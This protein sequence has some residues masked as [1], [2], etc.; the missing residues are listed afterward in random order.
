MLDSHFS[1]LMPPVLSSHG[2][3]GGPDYRGKIGQKNSLSWM[4]LSM[5]FSNF[6][7]QDKLI[8]LFL[9]LRELQ[10]YNPAEQ[11]TTN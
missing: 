2:L 4:N 3:R 7:I 10:K 11:E 5:F 6:T 1:E 8:I 9:A